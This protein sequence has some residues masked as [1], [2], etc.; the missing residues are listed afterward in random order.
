MPPLL[1][2]GSSQRLVSG[3]LTAMLAFI[4]L[5]YTYYAVGVDGGT[6]FTTTGYSS[7]SGLPRASYHH[8]AGVLRYVNPRIGTYGI[9]PNGNGGMIPSVSPPFGMTRWTPQ[10]RENFISQCPYNELDTHIHGFQATHQPAIWMGESGQV[11]L[12]PGV[13]A[14]RPSFVQRAHRFN[15][16]DE[17]STPYVYQVTVNAEAETANENLTESI[18]SPVPG[19]AQPVPDDVREGANGRTRRDLPVSEVGRTQVEEPRETPSWDRAIR[20][21]MTA[22]AHVGHMRFDFP[23][24][25]PDEEP[26]V[27]VQA[28]RK[29]W[30]G[31]ININPTMREISGTNN[32]RQDYLLGPLKAPQ[33]NSHFVSRFSRPFSS[34]SVTLGGDP[35]PDV[36]A[37]YGSEIGAYVR[38]GKASRVEVRTGVSFVSI[39]QARKN[40]D[41]EAPTSLTFDAAV[42]NLKAAWLE[43]LRRVTIE[44]VNDTDSDH[45][46]RTIW[47]TG[48]FHA[49]QYPSDFSEPTGNG[50]L[51]TF[52]SGYT[53]RV[54][55]SNDSYYQSWSIWDTFRAEHS[56]LTL[57]APER[58]NSM[59]RSLLSIYD[60][61]GRLPMWANVVETNIMIGTHV[62][63]VLANALTRGFRDFNLSKAWEAVEKNAF[64]PPLN[65]TTLLYYDREAET[66]DEVRAGLTSYM[67]HGY[68]S[69]DGWSESGSR[70]LDYA[71]DDHAAGVVATYA[72]KNETANALYDRSMNYHNIYNPGT[73]FM[74]AK[75]LNGTWAGRDQGW[76]EGDDW[77]Y[78]FNV[79]HDPLGLAKL[80]GGKERMKAKLDEY[81]Q[82][83]H[84]DHSNE[85]S[86]HAPYM[87]AAI[88][89]PN[90]TQTLVREIAYQNY[91]ATPAGLSGNEDLGQMSAWYLFSSL[92]FYPVNPASDEYVV[93]SP[94]FEEV[95]IRLPAGAAT[96][97]DVDAEKEHTLVITAPDAPTKPF[98]KD[99]KVDGVSV[100]GRPV[101]R[102]EQ[103]VTARKIEFEMSDTP[104]SWGR[105]GV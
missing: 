6:G 8:G 30:T 59:M 89:Y 73:T 55:V 29:N 34:F 2:L 42:D 102:H 35:I 91:N 20:T 82:G 100:E 23:S 22:S 9:T 4:L 98:V 56:L 3:I 95:T 50:D 104:A 33:F 77:I 72:G 49:L 51:R 32:Q 68:V 5:A 96:G 28:T 31:S 21:A 53:D 38:F 47:Y 94:F 79:M 90:D 46:P 44:G 62:D 85:P 40:L 13:G 69:N 65:D 70:T 105:G 81:F 84:N 63:A 75:N 78:T 83:G 12:T 67:S 19:G 15:K 37:G 27:T 74:E 93:G 101:L 45:D 76:T 25:P 26:Y 88:G 54:Y 7:E 16:R 11:V 58:V 80:M 64:V 71:F 60:W 103:I 99:L 41:L 97:G 86:H 52:Y 66:P 61:A 92:G 18:Y 14:I 43:K 1:S 17:V 48:L 39:E 10:T 57:F 87:Y 36:R 24:G